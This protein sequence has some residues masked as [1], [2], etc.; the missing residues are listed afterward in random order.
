MTHSSWI[1]SNYKTIE[2]IA[3]DLS[4]DRWSELLTYYIVWLDE[5]WEKFDGIPD[6]DERLKFTTTWLSQNVKWEKSS[7]N[8]ESK[9]NNLEFQWDIPDTTGDDD[10][11]DDVSDIE[12]EITKE[13][14]TDILVKYGHNRGEKI[15]KVRY[16]YINELSLQERVLYDLYFTQMMST[17]KIAKKIGIP[18]MATYTMIAD[19]KTKIKDKVC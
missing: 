6:N 8:I 12:D 19:L 1:S 3:K 2:R 10:I 18:V 11:F 5:K 4:R 16:I 15:L 9:T 14:V 17:R 13:A 7:F